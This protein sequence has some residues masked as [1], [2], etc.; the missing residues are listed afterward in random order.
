MP[1]QLSCAKG[2]CCCCF[3][4]DHGLKS[5]YG[6]DNGSE[7]ILTER[8]G[9]FG[10]TKYRLGILVSEFPSIQTLRNSCL[11]IKVRKWD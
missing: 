5:K 11:M 7:G 9:S 10:K 8:F 3:S 2:C 6:N 4:L 1:I